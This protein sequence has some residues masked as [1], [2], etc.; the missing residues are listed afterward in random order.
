MNEPRR[1]PLWLYPNLLGIDTPIVAMAWLFVFAKAWRVNY[2]PWPAFAALGLAVW[3]L[4]IGER[5]LANVMRG[6]DPN[7]PNGVHP[8]L[9]RHRIWFGVA[10][11]AAIIG[12]M[13]MVFTVL[14]MSIFS[15][16][17][18]GGVLIAGFFV[19]VVV[20]GG[21]S[22][23]TD[24]AKQALA[25]AA[26]AF[27]TAMT[28][29]AFLP[30]VD[31][32]EMLSTREIRAFAFFSILCLCAADFWSHAAGAGGDDSSGD[33]TLTIM[34]ALLGVVALSL[35]VMSQQSMVRPFYYGILTGAALLHLVNRRRTRFDATQLRVLAILILGAP[36]LVFAA[37]P[38][39]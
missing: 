29:H 18:I 26:F 33:L 39:W 13:V 25:G 34:V 15:Y 20:G 21:R 10:M 24:L 16:L 31:L 12:L 3:I 30:A 32:M 1:Q 37:F 22:D 4:V 14:P 38:S 7:F 11:T 6:G 23:E 27:G 2:L 35:A 9:Q 36:V 5:L 19:L 17:R 8:L 28:A